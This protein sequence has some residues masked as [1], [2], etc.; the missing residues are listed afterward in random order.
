MLATE[1][2]R[3]FLAALRRD[4]NLPAELLEQVDAALAREL[5]SPRAFLWIAALRKRDVDAITKLLQRR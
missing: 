3:E 2:Q 4:L 1:K 5:T